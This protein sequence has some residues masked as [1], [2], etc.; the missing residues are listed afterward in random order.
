MNSREK[1]LQIFERRSASG[2]AMWT[3]HPNDRTIPIY[4]E[5][6]GIEPTREAIYEYLDDDCRWITADSGYHHPEGKAAIDPSYGVERHTLS[7]GGCFADAETVADIEKYPWPNPDYCVFTDIYKQTEKF[8]D[9]MVFTGMWCPFFHQVAD[10]F[11]ME[12]YFIKMYECPEVVE[13]ATEHIVDYYVAANEKFFASLGDRADAM[14]FGNDFGTQR[15][16]FIS[17]E[18][19][20]KF[21]M[22][23]FKR[24]IAVG[25]KYGKKIMLHSCG[26]IYRIIPDLI[27]AGVDVLHPIQAKAAGMSA[28]E[29]SQFKHDIAFVGGIDAQSFFVRATPQQIKDEVYRVRELLGPNIVISP[30]HEEVLPNVPA[31]NILAMAEAARE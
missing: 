15:D 5:K 8:P 25:K 27:D 13:A 22:P 24:L 16:L 2:G 18:L 3:G 23:S 10:F 28:D 17:P 19:F 30:S 1:V 7:A 20:R 14:F 29:L 12:N 31:E 9:K 11:G 26:S 21:V 4:A 6:W